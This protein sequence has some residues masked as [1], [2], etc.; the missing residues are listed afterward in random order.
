MTSLDRNYREVINLLFALPGLYL[1]IHKTKGN[2]A[3]LG[4]RILDVRG[5][6]VKKLKR[7]EKL[8]NNFTFLIILVTVVKRNWQIFSLLF[9]RLTIGVFT[10]C[11]YGQQSTFFSLDVYNFSLENSHNGRDDVVEG[12]RCSNITRDALPQRERS[13]NRHLWFPMAGCL[14]VTEIRKSPFLVL[15]PVV[16]ESSSTRDAIYRIASRDGGQ[17][18]PFS[19]IATDCTCTVHAYSDSLW[20]RAR[21]ENTGGR[22]RE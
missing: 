14:P 8:E 10:S 9:S 18:L 19:A 1:N 2:I 11:R 3:I 7:G 16:V 17:S 6:E 21:D 12:K 5:E 20:A 22:K 15:F 13:F 4:Q